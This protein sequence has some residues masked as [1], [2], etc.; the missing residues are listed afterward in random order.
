[1]ITVKQKKTILAVGILTVF[2]AF[3]LCNNNNKVNP[4]NPTPTAQ[5]FG[6]FQVSLMAEDA[7]ASVLGKMYDGPYPPNMIFEE[8]AASG[9]CRLY[10]RLF[11]FCNPDCGGLG[12]CV[13]GDTCQPYPSAVD[14][15]TVTM[16]G[17][18]T[19]DGK[20]TFSMDPINNTY[21][22]T[23]LVFPPCSEGD[24]ITLEAAG[25]SSVSAF[26]LNIKGIGPLTL[27]NDTI[28]MVDGQPINLRWTPPTMTGISTIFVLI[29][30]SY[31]GGTKAKIECDCE[32]NGSL[33][34]PAVLL[35]SLKTFGIS[36]YPKLEISRRAIST[37]T[38]AKAKI[39]IESKVAKILYIPGIINCSLDTDC[40][41]GQT[42]AA[43]LRC[44]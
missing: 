16:S 28:K 29:D 31:H 42:C 5:T 35:D 12:A 38:S 40:P 4:T 37:D 9:S 13:K 20:T 21:Q 8:T 19:T 25:S 43:D 14:M 26:T 36:G 22:F 17:L 10:K 1:M 18:S 2:I 30:I 33:T 3:E 23:S 41:A 39:V 44:R 32:D 15:G 24:V 7:Y 34:I 6:T 11:P 27:L